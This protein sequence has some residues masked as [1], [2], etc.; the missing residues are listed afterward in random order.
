[1]KIGD[2]VKFVGIGNLGF[3][4]LGIIVRFDGDD[5]PV[6]LWSNPYFDNR[7]EANY[8][9]NIVVLSGAQEL[10]TAPRQEGAENG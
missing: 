3:R 2:L 6:V 4:S 1:M 8:R 7:T 9:K 10:L 5:D